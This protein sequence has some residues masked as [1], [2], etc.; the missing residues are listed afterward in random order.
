MPTF[1]IHATDPEPT[2]HS[3]DAPAKEPPGPMCVTGKE[4]ARRR[5][6]RK[7]ANKSKRRNR[8]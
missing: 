7:I 4:I 6:A 8:K 1:E 5:K 3:L 2:H